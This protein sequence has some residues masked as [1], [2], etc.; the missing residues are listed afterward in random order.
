M[1]KY[2]MVGLGGC[3]GSVVRFWVGSYVGSKMGVRFPYGTLLINITGSFAIGMIL[4]LFGLKTHW[5]PNWRYLAS[6]GFLGGYTTFSSFEYETLRT[7]QDG[8]VGLGILYVGLSV[9]VGFVAV[10]GG[11]IAGRALS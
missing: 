2:L 10:W 5:S 1:L 11:V 7:I 8:Q 9:F 6:I 3:L 4:T